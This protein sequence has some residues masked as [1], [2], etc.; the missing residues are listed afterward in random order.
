[1]IVLVG[2][3]RSRTMVAELARL[4]WGRMWIMK[5]PQ[6]YSQTEPWGFDNG[7]F[8]AWHNSQPWNADAYLRRLDRA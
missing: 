2:D 5:R 1:M 4:G 3:T 7:A 8:S 6:F